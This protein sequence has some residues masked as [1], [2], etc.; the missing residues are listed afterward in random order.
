[1]LKPSYLRPLTLLLL[2]AGLLVGGPALAL[3][4]QQAKERG[5]VG[6]TPSGYLAVVQGGADASR[7]VNDVNRLRKQHY[8][9]IA[10]RNGTS[11][12]AV[13][14][15]AGKKAIELTPAGQY[16]QLPNGKWV[17]K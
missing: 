13:E 11:L 10:K 3:D 12:A 7:V 15:L 17:R 16:I 6:E 14:A 9:S 5:L 2:L 1:M 4:L 8:L